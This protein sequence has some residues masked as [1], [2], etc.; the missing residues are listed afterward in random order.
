M[1]MMDAEGSV[2]DL[3]QQY[4]LVCESEGTPKSEQS[5]SPVSSWSEEEE[6]TVLRK[7][8]W[9]IMPILTLS[10]STLMLNR[11]N[12]AF[13]LNNGFLHDVG[14]TQN[15]FNIG[16]QLLSAGIVLL[17]IPSNLLLYRVGPTIWIGSQIVAWSLVGTLQSFQKG[18][19]TYLATRLL[20]GL[21]ESGF[22][23]A[24]LFIL[25]DWYKTFE[26]ATR[27]SIY[28]AGSMGSAALGS[29]V[30]YGVI[31]DLDGRGGLAGWQWLFI[32]EGLL[33]FLSGVTF[34]LAFPK[35]TSNPV[36]VLGFQYF[37]EREAHIVRQR[38]LLDDPTKANRAGKS[39]TRE[40]LRH[41]FTNWRLIPH[42]MA[43]VAAH[44]PAQGVTDDILSSRISPLGSSMFNPGIAKIL[45]EFNTS[46][47]ITATFVVSIYFLGY[48]FGPLVFAPISEI[49]GRVY[50]YHLGNFSFV[51]VC[52]GAAMSNNMDTLLA[53][54]FL[55]GVFGSAPTTVGI[56]SIMDLIQLEWRGRAISIWAI[57]PLLGPCI[58]PVIGG[59]VVENL[60]WR[61]VYWILA[62][63]G[64]AL[65]ILGVAFMQETYAPTLLER[66]A[67]RL[68]KET[69][70]D[71]L[72]ADMDTRSFGLIK[73]AIIR[74]MKLL[75]TT[76]LVTLIALY[77][78]ISFGI[79][80]LLTATFAFVYADQYHFGEATL[81]LTFLPA[82]IGM[83][84]A[85]VGFGYVAD[86]LVAVD[87]KT[88]GEDEPFKPEVKLSP[89]VT[90]PASVAL[91]VGLFVYGWTTQLQAHWIVPMISVALL[92][93][94][95]LGTT[96]CLSNYQIDSYPEYASSA[97]AAV[98]LARSL[99]GALVPLGGLKFF[100]NP[101]SSHPSPD[102]QQHPVLHSGDAVPW[103]FKPFHQTTRLEDGSATQID[104]LMDMELMNHYTAKAYRTITT[105]KEIS[106]MY[107]Y[108]MPREALVVPTL[109]EE[110][111]AFA[112]FH[113]AYLNPDRRQN[114]SLTAY[115]HQGRAIREM[116]SVLKGG[117][118]SETCHG[119]YAASIFVVINAFATLPS[120][121]RHNTSF[122]PIVGLSDIF[123]LVSGITAIL[124]SSEEALRNGTM[125]GLFW[126]QTDPPVDVEHLQTITKRL[127]VV[128]LN[129]IERR[130][131]SDEI[132]I[133]VVIEGATTLRDAIHETLS[134]QPGAPELKIAFVWPL[135]MSDTFLGLL[136]DRYPPTMVI[137]AYYSVILYHGATNC[138]FLTNWAEAL[139]SHISRQLSGTPYYGFIEWPIAM[140]PKP[141]PL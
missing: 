56:G 17:E 140:V 138:W 103:F 20:L 11:T 27:F 130:G 38:V 141:A 42:T 46:S 110:I 37:S 13:A 81:G 67:R 131:Q 78:G 139:I 134:S 92:C 113:L 126:K 55:M 133:S 127:D 84:I 102:T 47:S 87:E 125:K 88:R 52:V 82:G 72:R 41:V 28:F 26:S 12:I 86:Y 128:L 108:D 94:G 91:P 104:R 136:R 34:I 96:T 121:E 115:Q 118:T 120:C 3:S 97:S 21:C 119:T 7:I 25:T 93:F 64:G 33:A 43:T 116:T 68:R 70:N 77:V 18:L 9:L 5:S 107:Q 106:A 6:S 30:A 111:L 95:L 14:I 75:F 31:R 58:G 22:T 60:G 50:L 48:A 80:N 66:K 39:V 15:E 79:L 100:H 105:S 76:P 19:P 129:L 117:L 62:I 73:L 8:D 16:Q 54:R 89:W 1:P 90:M 40:E 35:S 124:A 4:G 137:L 23:L 101:A 32:I 63:V 61:W 71:A 24:G 69:G 135:R 85:V 132:E 36:S 29:L 74:P 99:V 51:L 57:G 65:G 83:M 123:I 59:Y 112:A 122:D 10:F 44:A 2:R 109:L 98:T 45:I 53:L 114:Y 49:Y